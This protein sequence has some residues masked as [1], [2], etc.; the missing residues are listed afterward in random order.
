[1]LMDDTRVIHETTPIQPVAD[2]GYRDT[3]VLTCRAETF[4][5]AAI[6]A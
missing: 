5:D 4:Q 2:G 6:T 3:L 1:M